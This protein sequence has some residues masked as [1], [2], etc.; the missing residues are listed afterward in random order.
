MDNPTTTSGA[1]PVPAPAGIRGYETDPGAGANPS[2]GSL[3]TVPTPTPATPAP[4]IHL[5]QPPPGPPALYPPGT[6]AFR[7]WDAAESACRARTMWSAYA[8]PF[9]HWNSH[10]GAAL[11]ILL[12]QGVDLNAFYD[13]KALNFF[14]QAV[15]GRTVFSDESPDVVCHEEGHAVLDSVQP[16]L[17]TAGLTECAAFHEAF[18]DMS[19]MLSA[20]QLPQLRIDV[21][22]ETGGVLFRNSRLS[23][24]AEQL[25]WA[26]RQIQPSAVDPDC[27]RNAVN[28]FVYHDPATLPSSAPASG[29]SSEA[30]SFSRVFSSAFLLAMSNVFSTRAVKDEATLHAVATEMG[31]LLIQAIRSAP[32]V[33]RYYAAV[34]GAMV[35]KAQATDHQALRA[36]FIKK[37]ILPPN[38]PLTAAA[39]APLAASIASVQANPPV[40]LP[41]GNYA[42]DADVEVDGGDTP[43]GSR[44]G[45]APMGVNA[46]H[47]NDPAPTDAA[48]LFLTHLLQNDRVALP[49]DTQPTRNFAGHLKTHRLAKD[50]NKYRLERILFDCGLHT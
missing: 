27:L 13:R 11:P 19:A 20:L 25:G 1:T 28:T 45:L 41:G 31:T 2:G 3:I 29:L 22:A 48:H 34:A 24:L 5:Q 42:L 21:L 7:Y 23:R 26:I 36:A 43:Q 37:M 15:S 33:A 32:V 35:T 46:Q 9:T 39:A 16:R 12:D 8:A 30:H 18:G 50:Q 14:H 4:A 40:T 49:N 6:P 44:V 10:V 38:F 47:L 17:F